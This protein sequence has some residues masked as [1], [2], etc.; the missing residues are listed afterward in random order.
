MP[1]IHS[2]ITNMTLTLYLLRHGET[3]YSQTGG[4]CG[5]LDPP[6][7]SAGEEMAQSVAA[8]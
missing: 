3:I 7:T 1:F 4:Y 6:L 5:E 8:A 2:P